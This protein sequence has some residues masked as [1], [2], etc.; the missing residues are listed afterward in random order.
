MWGE[1]GIAPLL[2]NFKLLQVLPFWADTQCRLINEVLVQPI[3]PASRIEQS[4][5]K[6][7]ER[8]SQVHSLLSSAVDV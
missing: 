4:K 7:E 5:K 3:G 8:R 6:N 2:L 1:G